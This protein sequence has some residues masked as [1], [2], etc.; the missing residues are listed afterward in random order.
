MIL[1]LST[2]FWCL[3]SYYGIWNHV[4]RETFYVSKNYSNFER[5]PVININWIFGDSKFAFT[6]SNAFKENKNENFST[7][8]GLKNLKK[9]LQL[10]HPENSL[11]II[12]GTNNFT[13]NLTLWN[14]NTLV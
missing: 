9:R 4:L 5:N 2:V 13:V 10:F 11:E 7:Q 1:T 3:I 8:T 14:L 12:E 6:I